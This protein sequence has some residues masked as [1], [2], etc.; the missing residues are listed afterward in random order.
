[1]YAHLHT[2]Q[3]THTNT[4]AHMLEE[5][6]EELL[7]IEPDRVWGPVLHAMW[8]SPVGIDLL[9]HLHVVTPENWGGLLW[10]GG[11][12]PSGPPHTFP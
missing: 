4:H 6:R 9:P 10:E 8:R 1:M 3:C 2:T 7:S 5:G 12:A 11:E